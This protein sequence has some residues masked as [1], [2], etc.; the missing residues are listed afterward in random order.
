MELLNQDKRSSRKAID[1][2]EGIF[3]TFLESGANESGAFQ[4]EKRNLKQKQK[5]E[6]K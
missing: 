6:C 1:D 4:I 2:N 5:L 3:H